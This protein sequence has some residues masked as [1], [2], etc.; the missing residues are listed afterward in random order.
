[1]LLVIP[2]DIRDELNARLDEQIAAHPD[3][4]ADRDVLFAQLVDHV[5]RTGVIPDF[6]LAKA[7]ASS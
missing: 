3:A 7:G 5:N 1:M 2:N 4:A 6:S